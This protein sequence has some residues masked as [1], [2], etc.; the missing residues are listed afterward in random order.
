MGLCQAVCPNQEVRLTWL[1]TRGTR[2]TNTA[3]GLHGCPTLLMRKPRY[4]A[5]MCRGGTW[6]LGGRKCTAETAEHRHWG[7]ALASDSGVQVLPGPDRVSAT[8]TL[9]E[10]PAQ[11]TQAESVQPQ[12]PSQ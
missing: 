1:K 8:V 2:V 7:R 10:W 12:R 4:G 6:I 3:H 5:G 9:E 11:H